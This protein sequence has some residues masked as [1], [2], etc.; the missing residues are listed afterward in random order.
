[1][2]RK[3][4]YSNFGPPWPDGLRTGSFAGRPGP[5]QGF[6]YSDFGFDPKIDLIFI[7]RVAQ[8]GHERLFQIYLG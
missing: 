3:E 5:G 4:I 7:L 1:M 6:R 2:T 8:N